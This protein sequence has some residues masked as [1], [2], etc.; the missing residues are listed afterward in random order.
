MAKKEIFPCHYMVPI[1]KSDRD[2]MIRE[3]M[4]YKDCQNRNKKQKFTYKEEKNITDSKTNTCD[5]YEI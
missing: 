1:S 4:N 3:N 5:E 2:I